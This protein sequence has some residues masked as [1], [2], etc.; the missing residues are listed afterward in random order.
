MKQFLE[1]TMTAGRPSSDLALDRKLRKVRL[2]AECI[3]SLRLWHGCCTLPFVN[4]SQI[5]FFI[6]T[7]QMQQ[8]Y[9]TFGNDNQKCPDMYPQSPV[10]SKNVF[11]AI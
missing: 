8:W 9:L 1:K 3:S 4:R 10:I 11:L 7:V 2:T 6:W 5:F